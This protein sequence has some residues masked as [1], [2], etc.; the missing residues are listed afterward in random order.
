[1]NKLT[2]IEKK[3]VATNLGIDTFPQAT[4]DKILS[5]LEEIIL[6][7]LAKTVDAKLTDEERIMIKNGNY[8][9]SMK[10]RIEN[11]DDIVKKVSEETVDEFRSELQNQVS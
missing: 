10:K 3:L 2:Q 9:E 8:T 6:S 1:M 11:F 7:H 4:Q 5:R